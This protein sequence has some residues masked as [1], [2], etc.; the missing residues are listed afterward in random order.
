MNLPKFQLEGII[1]LDFTGDPVQVAEK[2][3]RPFVRKVRWMCNLGACLNTYHAVLSGLPDDGGCHLLAG[4]P[5]DATWPTVFYTFLTYESDVRSVL[6][7]G[8]LMDADT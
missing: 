5:S 4:D 6:L 3:I 7:L 8:R 2:L 1:P